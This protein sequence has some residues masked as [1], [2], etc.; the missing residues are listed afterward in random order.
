LLS[1]VLATEP[2]CRAKRTRLQRRARVALSRAM[3]TLAPPRPAPAVTLDGRPDPEPLVRL[4][5]EAGG[6]HQDL[7]AAISRLRFCDT[8]DGQ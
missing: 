1:V 7:V 3:V 4:Y 5:Y 8:G 6:D 2:L